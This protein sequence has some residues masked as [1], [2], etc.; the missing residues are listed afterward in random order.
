MNQFSEEPDRAKEKGVSYLHRTATTTYP[1]YLPVLGE[2]SRSWSYKTYPAAKLRN[3]FSSAKIQ[4]SL[5]PVDFVEI[6]ENPRGLRVKT[7]MSQ[8]GRAH[9]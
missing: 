4:V 9:V 2:F 3:F 5:Q 1:C 7:A 6:M 8:I